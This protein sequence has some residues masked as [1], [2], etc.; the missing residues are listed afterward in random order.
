MSGSPSLEQKRA[1]VD[2]FLR[3]LTKRTPEVARLFAETVAT[4]R[5]TQRN[6]GSVYNDLLEWCRQL[7]ATDR[8]EI[9]A[10]LQAA[11]GLPLD[12]FD[13]Q[14]IARIAR[15]VTRGFLRSDDE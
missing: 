4:M 6:V 8:R 3:L 5:P 14:R 2:A 11:V 1:F 7:P 10:D 15:L 13:Q 9:S 12:F